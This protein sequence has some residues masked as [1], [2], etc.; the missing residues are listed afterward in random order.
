VGRDVKR[1]NR[2]ALRI[3]EDLTTWARDDLQ[4]EAHAL[5]GSENE[6]AARGMLESGQRGAN[7][8]RIRDEFAVR[9][10]DRK[11]QATR[12]LEDLQDAEGALHRVY[13]QLRANPWPKN[14]HQE[15]V[16]RITRGWN[17]RDV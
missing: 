16:D 13:R 10:R 7:E 17:D 5:S 8:R 15:E 9:W 14:P 2:E 12:D 1:H 11:R 4:K 6:L 3:H